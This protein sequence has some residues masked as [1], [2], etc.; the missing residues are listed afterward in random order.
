MLHHKLVASLIG[1]LSLILL[2]ATSLTVKAADRSY[3]L[4][5]AT[6]GGTYY[7]VGVAIATLVKVKLEPR[8]KIAMSAISSAGSGENVKLLREN[9][10][11]F[12]ILQ[13]LYGAW[14]WKG[15]GRVEP[16]GPQKHL[17]SVT[18][19]WQNVEHI[20]VNSDYVKSGTV[21]DL[22]N[23]KNEKF[24]IGKRNSGTE[25]SGRH[26]LTGLGIDPDKTFNLVYQGYGPSA[27]SL[28]NGTIQGMNIPAGVPVS[29]VSRAFAV[30][31]GKITIL[32]FSD[33][34]MT[35]ANGDYT[36]W[37]RYVIDPDTYPAQSKVVNTIAQPNFLAVRE[38][39]DKDAVYQITKA[40]YENLSF[41]Q[42]IHKATKAMSIDKAVAGLPIP[43]HPGAAQ[44]Y[45]DAGISLPDELIAR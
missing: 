21:D 34:Q 8:H 4:T 45:K 30:L 22:K 10:A 2:S 6:T 15:E 7:P 33:E 44:Y 5:T 24:S 20:I 29:A 32:N 25:G 41:L 26:I 23:L 27:D 17:R 9:Q 18:M 31:G 39:V 35:R 11:Q 38:D 28:Q 16:D 12:G 19:L 42:N 43:L 3:I 37:T 1:S 14:A 13:G 40:I 36:L